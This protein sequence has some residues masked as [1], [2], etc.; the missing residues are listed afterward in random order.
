[1][2]SLLFSV[3]SRVA[4]LAYFY[5]SPKFSS[6]SVCVGERSCSSHVQLSSANV[7]FLF[8]FMPRQE[9]ALHAGSILSSV[10]LSSFCVLAG[11]HA[12]LVLVQFGSCS[13]VVQFVFCLHM[14]G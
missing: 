7:E 1:M 2:V 14:R 8:E 10:I 6:C 13:V 5:R 9:F 3:E 4:C 11:A 12:K